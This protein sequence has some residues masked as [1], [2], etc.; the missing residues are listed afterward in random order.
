MS[1]LNHININLV[2]GQIILVGP[3]HNKPAEITKI[4]FH[5]KS[6]EVCI[7]TTRGPMQVLTFALC[8]QTPES[9]AHLANPADRYR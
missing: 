4:E 7:N 3:N 6:G 8:E 2:V 5:E 9:S 1:T